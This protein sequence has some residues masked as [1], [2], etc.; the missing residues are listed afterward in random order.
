MPKPNGYV[1]NY[2]ILT[3]HSSHHFSMCDFTYTCIPKSMLM[4]QE[5]PVIQRGYWTIKAP[6]KSI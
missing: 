1:L 3:P 4:N 5:I 2:V 6:Y